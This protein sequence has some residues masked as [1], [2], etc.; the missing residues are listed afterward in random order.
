MLM[1]WV[2]C[3]ALGKVL[4]FIRAFGFCVSLFGPAQKCLG[5]GGLPVLSLAVWGA[6]VSELWPSGFEV[7]PALRSLSFL[8]LGPANFEF[9]GVRVA[10]FW[11]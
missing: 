6:G 7:D 10:S 11:E 3:Q 2:L 8:F 4:G 1:A 9:E 5:F